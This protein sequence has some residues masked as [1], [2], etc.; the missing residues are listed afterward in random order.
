M[1]IA[2][3]LEMAARA[4]ALC[5]VCVLVACSD[6]GGGEMSGQV[7][8]RL[9]SDCAI[10]DVC[11]DSECVEDEDACQGDDCPCV[12]DSDCPRGHGCDTSG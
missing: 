4:S 6:S 1:S 8:C 12:V 3:W 11:V 5:T 7:A 2:R 9:H 10:G